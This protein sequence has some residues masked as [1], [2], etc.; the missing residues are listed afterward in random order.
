M[1]FHR[2]NIDCI[3]RATVQ[4]NLNSGARAHKC[5]LLA[6]IPCMGMSAG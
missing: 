4:L 6:D 3:G 1:K 5:N 2:R